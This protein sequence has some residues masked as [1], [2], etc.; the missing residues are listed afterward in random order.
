MLNFA[1]WFNFCPTS[2]TITRSPRKIEESDLMWIPGPTTNVFPLDG[3]RLLSLFATPL[4]VLLKWLWPQKQPMLHI[5]E[6]KW[7]P[8][9]MTLHDALGIPLITMILALILLPLLHWAS[10]G[11][12]RLWLKICPPQS[13]HP[14]HADLTRPASEWVG[15]WVSP[16]QIP[17]LHCTLPFARFVSSKSWLS[18]YLQLESFVFNIPEITVFCKQNGSKFCNCNFSL[19][20]SK[21]WFQWTVY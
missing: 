7:L 12:Q 10:M 6:Q 2:A 13:T 14:D 20:I 21:W 18:R 4:T 8:S 16:G 5:L 15:L 19:I 9:F 3:I 17:L 1:L 11:A